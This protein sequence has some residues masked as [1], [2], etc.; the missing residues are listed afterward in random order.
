MIVYGDPQYEESLAALVEQLRQRLTAL[1][2]GSGRSSAADMLQQL[3]AALILTGQ[4]EQAACDALDGQ[5]YQGYNSRLHEATAHVAQAF[6]YTWAEQNGHKCGGIDPAE[7]LSRSLSQ[8]GEE[9]AQPDRRVT[10]KMPEG[11]AFYTLYPEQ[12][13]AAALRWLADHH[14]IK[15]KTAVVVG[16]RSIGTTLAAVVATTLRAHGWKVASLTVRPT[17]HPFQREA[18][19]APEQVGGAEWGLV[20]D[21]GP[22]LSGSSMSGVGQALVAA[23]LARDRISFFPAHA[24]EPGSAASDEIRAWWSSTPRYVV[25]LEDVRFNG[26][27]LSG[28]LAAWLTAQDPTDPVVRIEDVS[29]GQWRRVLYRESRMWPPTCAPFE[30]TKYLC[31]TESGK[32]VLFKFEGLCSTPGTSGTTAEIVESILVE[33]AA[34]GWTPAPLGVVNGF[35]AIQWVDG[36]PLDLEDCGPEMLRHMGGYI[37][38][39]AGAPLSAE[40]HAGATGR[41]AD[42]LYWN[43]WE[44]LGEDVAERTRHRADGLRDMPNNI[45]SYGDGRMAPREWMRTHDGRILKSGSAGHSWDHTCIGPQPVAWDLAGAIVEWGLDEEGSRSLLEAFYSAGGYPISDSTLTFYRMAYA[46]FR[47]GQCHLCASMSPH[48]PAEQER[49][50]SAYNRYKGDLAT[51]L[52]GNG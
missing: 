45:R 6:Y 21:E 24:N 20:V 50:W 9:T 44:A 48:D 23:G 28:S 32:R 37:A 26:L 47:V 22:G 42:M 30:R 14:S 10:V 1:L 27:S 18:Y 12:Y 3:R 46:A 35:V 25:P 11:F 17:G 34:A 39:V 19:I 8:L 33:R 43:T 16:V 13:C 41:L 40:Q 36:T 15:N 5:E 38:V 2:A 7:S 51:L 4:L 31:T 52:W 49:L 29:G